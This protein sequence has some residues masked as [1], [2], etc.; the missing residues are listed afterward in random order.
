MFFKRL[1]WKVN[2]QNGLEKDEYDE[3][4]AY[5]LIHK[6]E[7]GVIT[8]CLRLIEMTNN[9]MFDGP[10]RFLLPDLK[11]YKRQG[12]W[13]VSRFAVDTTLGAAANKI[14]LHLIACLYYFLLELQQAELFFS[15]SYPSVVKLYQRYGIYGSVFTQREIEGKEV[16]V[17]GY[18][19]LR[20][21]YEKLLEKLKYDMR[22]PLFYC[23]N[24]YFPVFLPTSSRV[25]RN[26]TY[27]PTHFLNVQRIGICSRESA[28]FRM[29]RK[30]RLNRDVNDLYCFF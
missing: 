24:P 8:G 13:E 26:L 23:L 28:A 14:T 15:I 7:K 10:F 17:I 5:Y 20:L 6:D 1:S 25:E 4:N 3:K 9:C 2:P 19:P 21:T 11:S 29:K 16:M 30:P 27:H 18:P 22:E 12:M